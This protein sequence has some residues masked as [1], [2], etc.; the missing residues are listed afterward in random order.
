MRKHRGDVAKELLAKFYPDGA[1]RPKGLLTAIFVALGEAE[2]R[3]FE[4]CLA[5]FEMRSSDNDNRPD[6]SP[7][8]EES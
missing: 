2:S 6:P 5:I 1:L 4:D 3:G 8:G 7:I